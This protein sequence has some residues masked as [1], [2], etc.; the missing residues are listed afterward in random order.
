MDTHQTSW[1]PVCALRRIPADRLTTLRW[2]KATRSNPTGA[3]VEL[4]QLPGDKV[5]LRNSRDPAGPTLVFT[6]SA[7]AALVIA[8]KSGG[9]PGPGSRY[10]EEAQASGTGP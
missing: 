7:I 9:L 1:Y 2:H 5:A 3:C 6:R 10:C 4:A 8:A